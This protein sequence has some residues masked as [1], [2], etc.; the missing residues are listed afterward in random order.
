LGIGA[1]NRKFSK[2]ALYLGTGVIISKSGFPRL[3][4]EGK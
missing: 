3:K 4:K 2:K 1:G